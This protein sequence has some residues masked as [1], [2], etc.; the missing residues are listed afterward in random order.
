M[1]SMGRWRRQQLGIDGNGVKVCILDTG[2]DK[3]HPNLPQP[4]LE[5]DFMFD[6]E[7]IKRADVVIGG[8]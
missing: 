5:H 1:G 3:T 2:M 7:F 4:I 8:S 6:D